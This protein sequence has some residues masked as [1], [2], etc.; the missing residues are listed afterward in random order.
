MVT[1]E[2]KP[3]TSNGETGQSASVIVASP[4]MFDTVGVRIRRGRSLTERDDAGAPHVAVISER[5][6]RAVFQSVDV[7]GRTIVVA[8]RSRVS[9]LAAR[10]RHDDGGR[11]VGRSGRADQKLSGRQTPFRPLGP[12]L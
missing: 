8:T 5:L 9:R 6:A 2:D 10:I 4:E 7:V 1:T 3:L 12:A 11:C